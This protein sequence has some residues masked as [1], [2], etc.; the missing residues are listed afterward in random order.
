MPHRL[1]TRLPGSWCLVLGK[2]KTVPRAFVLLAF[3]LLTAPCCGE[4]TP[5]ESTPGQEV[6]ELE[7]LPSGD[8]LAADYPDD[9]G[10]EDHP[11]VIFADD[12]ESGTLDQKWDNLTEPDAMVYTSGDEP[13]FAGTR[14]LRITA[15]AG[16]NNG[17]SA[18]KWF[19]PGYDRVYARFAVR[20]AE[21][22]GYVHHFVHLMA[23]RADDQ[24]SA[25]G[26]AGNRPNG[27]DFFTTGIEPWGNWGSYP[28]PGAWNFYTYWPDMQGAP[29]GVNFWGNS[30]APATPR[31][32]E[33][34]RWYNI[35][36]LV[37]ANDPGAAN[38]REAFWIDGELAGEFDGFE[39]RTDPDLKVNAFWLLFYVTGNEARQNDVEQTP[40]S[41]VWFDNV[42]VARDYIGPVSK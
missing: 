20:F 19:M 12:F 39:W 11:S 34:G 37:E 17:G 25:F 22:M 29:D 10:I 9:V 40:V 38:G 18:T 26:Q 24:W 8:G 30:F 5:T 3:L 16:E 4:E 21:D 33:L 7:P 13:V 27:T 23:N 1:L 28:A 42:V 15:T 6:R 41:R 36:V 2:A 32:P 35:E 31:I 14:A